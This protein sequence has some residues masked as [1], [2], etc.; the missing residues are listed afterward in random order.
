MEGE[1]EADFPPTWLFDNDDP[2]SFVVPVNPLTYTDPT[3]VRRVYS[4]ARRIADCFSR[5]GLFYWTSGG[6]TL[7]IVRHGGLI[8]WDDD[9]DICILEKD[10][11]KLLGLSSALSAEGLQVQ[12]SQPYALKIFDKTDSEPVNHGS[13]MHRFPF[14][15]VFVMREKKGLVALCNKVG[16]NTWPDEVYTLEQIKAV[17]PRKF[18]NVFLQCPGSPEEYLNSTYGISWNKKGATHFFN[19]LDAS[20]VR[21]TQFEMKSDM[22]LP[23]VPFQ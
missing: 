13:Y 16:R 7:G 18:G 15:D 23:A 12:R 9:I 19:H 14:C 10:E 8:P 21:S 1:S 11:D 6:T 4:L 5:F 17:A 2:K 3:T 22:F 20:C